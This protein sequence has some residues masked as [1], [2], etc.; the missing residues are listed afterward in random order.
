MKLGSIKTELL[1]AWIFELLVVIAWIIGFVLFAVVF[2]AASSLAGPGGGIFA[3]VGV[4]F[5]VFLLILMIPSIM[6]FRRTGK[7]RSAAKKGDIA[8]LKSLNSLGWAV[9]ALIFTGII[10]GIMLIVAHGPIDELQ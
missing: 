10:P 9:V 5:G 3:G 4:I 8:R 7:M 2:F 1:V 6:V